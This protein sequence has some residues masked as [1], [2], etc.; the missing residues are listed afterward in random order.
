MKSTTASADALTVSVGTEEVKRVLN[1]TGPEGEK[2][3][4]TLTLTTD[5]YVSDTFW[6]AISDKFTE[7]NS[8]AKT[9]FQS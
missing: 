7:L 5:C 2:A 3:K 6:A 8:S 1:V 4:I 9:I